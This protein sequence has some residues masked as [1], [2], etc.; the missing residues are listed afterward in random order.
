MR[1]VRILA[2]APLALLAVLGLAL[3]GLQTP[4]GKRLLASALSDGQVR[5]GTIEGFVPT[6]LAVSHIEVSDRDG[7]WLRVEGARL[8]W[9]FGSLF[10]GRLRVETLAATRV[11]LLRLPGE[12]P[13]A[14]AA[15]DDGP[16]RLPFDVDLR[17]LRIDDLHLAAAL[18]G[19]ESNWKVGGHG[20]LARDLGEMA[21][22]LGADRFDGPAGRLAADIRLERSPRRIAADVT[23]EE[24]RGGMVA[25]L[26]QQPDLP[27]ISLHLRAHGDEREGDAELSMKTGEQA[28][29]S[30]TARWTAE[31]AD[32]R[33]QASLETGPVTA[34]RQGVSWR[35]LRLSAE[36]RL[37]DAIRLQ[38]KVD[39]FALA[40]LDPRLPQPGDVALEAAIA[41]RDGD[42]TVR[43]FDIAT[44]LVRATGEGSYATA[45]GK[46]EL[47]ASV[48]V[49]SLAPLSALAGRELK[50]GLQARVTATYGKGAVA[51]RWD[52]ALAGFGSAGVP[53]DLVATVNL[54][55]TAELAADG[56]WT[57]REVRLA[58]DTGTLT[59]SGRGRARAGTLDLG[60][61]LPRLAALPAAVEG[62]ASAVASVVFGGGDPRLTLRVE[63]Y[64]LAWQGIA[65]GRFALDTGIA[66]D[67]RGAV[68]G[69]VK[70]DGVVEGRP[71]T[72]AGR[73][74]HD[75]ATGLSVPALQG[76][77]A[78]AVLDIAD[79]AV[80]AARTTGR[81]RLDIAGLE[82]IDGFAEA[83]L[84]GRLQAEVTA[85]PG[86]P[87]GRLDI[88]VTGGD[89]AAGGLSARTLDLSGHVD[90]PAGIAATDLS[91]VATGLGNAGG[92]ASLRATA[93]G[94]RTA[95]EVAAE[96]SGAG[97]A[98]DLAAKVE[99]ADGQIRIALS[100][101]A[102]RWR[103]IPVGLAAPARIVV[104]GRRI[105]VDPTALRA[106]GGRVT[107]RGALDP[108]ASD[109]TVELAGLP[110]ATIETLAPG[111]GL[112]GTLQA[113][114]RATGPMAAPRIEA[115]YS[116]TG[117]RLRR[118]EAAL[119]PSL[120]LQGT[121]TLAGRQ[122]SLDARL[123]AGADSS[124]SLKGT[125]RLPGGAEPLRS[126][127]AVGGAID[128][129]PFAPLLG[130]D[131]RGIAGRLRPAITVS[132]DGS[133]IGGTGTIDLEGGNVA[134]PESGLRL[135]N[136]EGRFVLQDDTLRIERLGF[137]A[138]TGSVTVGGT[139]RLD[140]T[141]GPA[142]A[143]VPALE[144]G[145]QRA[146]LV[147]RPDLTALVSAR[148]RVTGATTSAIEVAGDVTIDRAEITI[149]GGQSAAFPTVE[150][151]EI[152]RPGSPPQGVTPP[153][154]AKP[155]GRAPPPPGAT[156]VRLAL[157][158]RAP[159][160]VF[161]RGRGLDAEMGGEI[162][163]SGSPFAPTAIG[164][165]TVRR[166]AFTL[167]GRR[168]SFSK[169]V[170]TLD[171]L[172]AIDPR[173]DFL[174]T[175][176]VGSATI[177]VAITGTARAP[178]LAVTSSP[179]MPPDEAM[180]LLIFGK[181]AS[182]L[183]G[184]ELLQVASAVAELTGRSPGDSVLGHLRKGLGLDRLSVG[185]SSGAAGGPAGAGSVS[186]EA[187]RYVAPGV[188][189]GA[190][191]GAAGNSSRGVVQ[192]EVLDNLKLEGDI[193]ADSRG[194][195]GAKMEWDY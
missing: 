94:D 103:D 122:A 148:I 158:V 139:L 74:A 29:A 191:Q 145:A 173:L 183:G 78:G 132:V 102:G 71:L 110:L 57:L 76:R 129:A 194:R 142:P 88:K 130:N 140:A 69:T 190:R 99:P 56:A 53:D 163:V 93:R 192:I 161:V 162:A 121:G 46:A 134:L 100:K 169:G 113:R 156:P 179:A 7:P 166:G 30:G 48:D 136:G 55:G 105:V 14:A 92:L 50:G 83:G 111:T 44:A 8:A 85:D 54:A 184:S 61:D 1:A 182:Q 10:G 67:A 188:Y 15:S 171:N 45:A 174:A 151:R 87:A 37:A 43:S 79:L 104:A 120:S 68:S 97:L 125:A 81:A 176:S 9:S 118:P 20:T 155:S 17:A 153:A 18:G 135:S 58:N 19:E 2:I 36:G 86:A 112:E 175:T 170:V 186:L 114:L 115:T 133:R 26:L 177:G 185:S 180:A 28:M 47:R 31:G 172:D 98:G 138:G 82:E 5:I 187:G 106:G 109:M 23:L 3:A 101:F 89:L 52:G 131:I 137:R 21:V 72:L 159:Q 73:F 95:I 40:A 108:V 6:D 107:L 27:R 128:L 70:A 51:L 90:D 33:L 66:L 165:L 117:L 22:R 181:P 144:V 167:G 160:A 116:A 75:P 4:P 189:V 152:N 127:I 154:P 126:E 84:R 157:D 39:G 150:V 96:A 146:L 143:I 62:R 11:A 59:V 119:L 49:P 164:G 38:G 195:V 178:S 12:E 149:G 13:A 77:W 64:D 32:L 42:V 65:A 123:A 63:A 24:D 91:L 16:L 193:G 41:V 80:G 60:L 25:V 141:Q 35:A 34:A 168:L 124:L 147:S